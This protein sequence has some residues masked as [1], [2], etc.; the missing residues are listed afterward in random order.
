M[1]SLKGSVERRLESTQNLGL[2]GASDGAVGAASSAAVGT[3]V[4]A[5][6]GGGGGRDLKV[7]HLDQ[8]LLASVAAGTSGLGG[9]VVGGNVEGDE[10]NEVGADD[11]NTGHGS[12]F[13]TG[14]LAHVRQPGEVGGG[15][16]GVGGEVDEAWRLSVLV[17]LLKYALRPLT[18]VNDELENLQHG[19][20]LLPPDAHTTGT[21]EVVP[22]HHNVDQQVDGDGHPL[23]GSHT[24]KLR[25]AEKSSGTVVVGVEEGQWLLLEDKED[26]VNELDVFV[27]VVELRAL[28]NICRSIDSAQDHLRSTE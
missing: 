18:D 21:L 4:D 15:E 24:D 22:V 6:V 8:G 20:V 16:V 7:P 2:A 25:V 11:T 5:T 3:T 23:H 19:D 26:G 10:E 14:A 1:G 13:L 27:Q 28:V 9:L 17:L 12:E